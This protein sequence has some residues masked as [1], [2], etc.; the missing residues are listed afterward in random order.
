MLARFSVQGYFMNLC[1]DDAF[2]MESLF[3]SLFFIPRSI[4][5]SGFI[6]SLQLLSDICPIV[7][8]SIKSGQKLAAGWEVPKEWSVNSATL[9]D[10]AGNLVFSY[11]TKT[12]IF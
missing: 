3:D 10:S 4:T 11:E 2:E 1:G 5:G 8:R 12:L 7:T 9:K 6:D